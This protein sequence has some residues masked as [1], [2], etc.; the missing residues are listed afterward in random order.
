MMPDARDR[1]FASQFSTEPQP[2]AVDEQVVMPG[3]GD[4][5]GSHPRRIVAG[6]YLV[7]T[8]TAQARRAPE[9]PVGC[10]L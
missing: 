3:A 6:A 9:L 2:V 4:R 1:H 5:P 8:I 7:R 10:V